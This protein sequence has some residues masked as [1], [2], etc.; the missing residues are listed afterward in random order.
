MS[1][2]TYQVIDCAKFFIKEGMY[3]IKEVEQMLADMKAEL[4]KTVEAL[5]NSAVVQKEKGEL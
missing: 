3:S 2:Y 5:Y 4:V 1:E